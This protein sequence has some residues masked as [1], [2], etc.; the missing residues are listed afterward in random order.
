MKKI[1]ILLSLLWGFQCLSATVVCLVT[2]KSDKLGDGQTS[3]SAEG[4]TRLETLK[5]AQMLAN[6]LSEGFKIVN[7]SSGNR[8]NADWST[9]YTLTKEK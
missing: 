6:L 8:A 7:I 3:C 1:G 5:P 2:V 9:V 4:N